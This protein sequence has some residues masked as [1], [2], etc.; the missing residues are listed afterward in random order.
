MAFAA[1][2]GHFLLGTAPLLV[3]YAFFVARKS[4]IV[5]LTL[6]SSFYWLTV[7]LFISAL[8]KGGKDRSQRL[9]AFLFYRLTRIGSMGILKQDGWFGPE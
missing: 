3:L 7:L 2:L 4:F 9:V 5:L 1:F 6:A 8:F